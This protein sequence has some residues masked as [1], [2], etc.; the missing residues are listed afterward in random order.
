MVYDLLITCVLII[1]FG[2]FD[3]FSSVYAFKLYSKKLKDYY[4][5]EIFE[6]NP[7]QRE[8]VEGGRYNSL[9]FVGLLFLCALL[10]GS[11]F[12]GPNE[13]AFF[14]GWGLSLFGF[15]VSRNIRT[16]IIYHKFNKNPEPFIGKVKETYLYTL[17]RLVG[18]VIGIT[19]FLFLIF[20][21]IPS[22]FTLGFA[23]GPLLLLLKVR[24]WKKM[25]IKKQ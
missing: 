24:S 14:Q 10:T 5:Y 4:E 9:H 15:I 11:Y 17:D 7:Y 25:Y 23:L 22:F 3:H 6:L 13:F 19:L 16:L 12:S 2:L 20:A 8:S 1:V 18:E 21:F